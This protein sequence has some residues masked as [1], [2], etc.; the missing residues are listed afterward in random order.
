MESFN[1]KYLFLRLIYLG[2]ILI[3][4]ET[5]INIFMLKGLFTINIVNSGVFQM[6]CKS[7][8]KHNAKILVIG[9]SVCDQ[10]YDCSTDNNSICSLASN[11][12]VTI[13]GYYFLI[14]NYLKVNTPQKVILL[15]HPNTLQNDLNSIG[16]NYFMKPF[17][18]SEYKN[19]F[20]KHLIER[21]HETPN[22]WLCQVPGIKTTSY[23]PNYQVQ[24]S[25][26][27][28]ITAESYIDSIKTF[29]NIQKVKFELHINPLSETMRPHVNEMIDKTDNKIIKSALLECT[30]FPDSLFID[31]VHFYRKH[32][33]IDFFN[34]YKQ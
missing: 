22:W 12:G 18:T 8:E 26:P 5:I 23:T 9:D 1:K 27:I 33:P 17:Y 14:N 24:P 13:A 32:I 15:I 2:G 31:K 25:F 29:C 20:N 30:F 19:K 10:L 4:I 11:Q 34:L 3:I 7:K 28:S 16:Y 21:V 6:I